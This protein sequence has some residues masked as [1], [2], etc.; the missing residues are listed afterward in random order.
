MRTNIM[1]HI[2]KQIFFSCLAIFAY[3]F[4]S[5]KNDPIFAAIEDEVKLKKQ[6]VQGLISGIVLVGNNVYSAN[7]KYVFTKKIGVR[8]EWEKI[9]TVGGM[10]TSLATDGTELY[11]AFIEKGVYVY[12]G[13]GWQQ[14][15]NSTSISKIASGT[16]I[17][18]TNGDNFVFILNGSSFEQ[19]KDSSNNHIKLN[20]TLQGGAG[21]YFGDASTIYSY[22]AGIASKVQKNELTSIKDL[23]MGEDENKVF[24]L[25]NSHIYHYDGSSLTGIKHQVLSPWSITYSKKQNLTLVGGSQGYK[26]IQLTG[27]SLAG[28]YVRLPGSSGS[29]TPASC[30]NQYNNSVGKWLL[31]PILI[32]DHNDGYIIYAGVGG[33]DTKYT[34]LWGFYNPEQL[35]WNRE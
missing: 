23:C 14:V 5:C 26:E 2:Q 12:R 3:I 13:G 19:L 29:T 20:N 33:A 35:E 9:E 22:N 17:I 7:P 25:T 27:T 11:A 8:G 31:R 24:V 16:S 28:S 21:K 30:F 34:G 4:L 1:K 10:C 15:A 18:G 32:I 6:S